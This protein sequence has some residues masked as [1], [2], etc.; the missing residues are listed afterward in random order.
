MGL[1]SHSGTA[2][3][4]FFPIGETA[5]D[6]ESSRR[7]EGR[8]FGLCECEVVGQSTVASSRATG[9]SGRRREAAD[10]E[11]LAARRKLAWRLT[12]GTQVSVWAPEV[13]IA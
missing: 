2:F 10:L 1:L 8:G 5:S 12:A 6:L 7:G 11:L 13:Y 3:T 9:S 4:F